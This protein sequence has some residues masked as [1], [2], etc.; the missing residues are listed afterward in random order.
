MSAHPDADDPLLTVEHLTHHFPAREAPGLWPGRRRAVV[1]AVDDV[2]LT[3]H[4]GETLA[5]VGESGSGKSTIARCVVRLL[6]PTAGRVVFAGRDLGQ[7]SRTQLRQARR[8][9]QIVFQDPS[10]TLDP[11]LSVGD[12]IAEP[13]R[14]FRRY[15]G[16]HH[17]EARVAE[18]LRLVGLDPRHAASRPHELSGGQRQRVGIA[19]ALALEPRLLVLDEPVSSLDVSVRA[20]V[21]TLLE[22]LRERLGL[23]YLL[24]AHD[25]AMVRHL[26]D[27]IAVLHLGMLVELGPTR[28]VL[29]APAHPYTRALVSAVPVADPR[30]RGRQAR[31]VL[32]GEP[33]SPVDPPSG[34]R[35]RTR[36]WKAEER[37]AVEVP[38]LLDRGGGHH[39]AC[40]FPE[41]SPEAPPGVVTEA[42]P[43]VAPRASPD[44]APEA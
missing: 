33:P 16:E 20:Q 34:C 26:A 41:A 15:R 9:L 4:A 23:S 18:L 17:G 40:H 21:I 6:E 39:D 8:E 44:V 42:S 19:R 13:L 3:V 22:D 2:S 29:D 5:L 24:I 14:I 30:E 27:R 35:F 38:P 31:I 7:L 43:D 10:A 37:C 28:Q 36:C 32:A 25:L 1:H 12:A 11:R